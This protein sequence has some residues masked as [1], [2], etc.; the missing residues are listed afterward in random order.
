MNKKQQKRRH[1]RRVHH[2]NCDRVDPAIRAIER[3]IMQLEGMT[4][5]E[6]IAN[7]KALGATGI[8]KANKAKLIEKISEKLWERVA[9]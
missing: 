4:K 5:P 3:Q 8:S 2:S 9:A 1:E 7:A 6:L